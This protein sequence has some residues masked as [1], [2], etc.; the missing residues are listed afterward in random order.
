LARAL[1]I[2]TAVN[3]VAACRRRR[4][5]AIDAMSWLL[6][7]RIRHY[8][9]NSIW[10]VP[11]VAMVLAKITVR[12]VY[13]LD[14]AMDW[15]ATLNPETTRA[16]LGTLAGAMFTFIVFV[17][18]ALLLV[19]QLA[20]AQLTPRVIGPMFRDPVTKVTL[21][22]FV[23]A[24]T[25]TLAAILRVDSEV[26]YLTSYIS[27]FSCAASVAVFLFLVDHVGKI[28]RPSSVFESVAAQAH[29]VIDSVYPRRFADAPKPPS[30]SADVLSEKSA[31]VVDSR[32]GGVLMAFDLPGL[33]SIAVRHNCVI[34]LLPQVGN[35]VAP[36]APLYR[37]YAEAEVPADSLH[38]SVAL[39]RERTME[40]DPA[41]AFRVIV[42]IA[43]KGLSPAINDP[44]T[45]VLAIDQIHHLLRHVGSRCLE[46]ERVRD[47]SGRVRLIYRTPDW[48][49]FV[50][51]AVTEIRQFGGTSI[52]IAR[53]LRAMLEDLVKAVPEERA[54]RL[55]QEL[56][57]LKQSAQRFFQDP[58]DRALAD[59]S[60]SQG[61]GGAREV[62]AHTGRIGTAVPENT[63][64]P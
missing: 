34:E 9:R 35:Y 43:S 46:D 48:E 25:F 42:D 45:A 17:C 36:G 2:G 12:L 6:R 18:S 20:S 15:D 61:V 10:I 38:Q 4:T 50:N 54:V 23:F 3:D 30:Q 49:D 7:Y 27:A 14:I 51:L 24:F 29:D 16:V 28:L 13:R 11:V 63:N 26:P 64:A 53:R 59:V 56:R 47:K 19:I 31:R 44:T 8:V 58:E 39:G 22:V 21:A 62:V 1:P 37:V 41:F 5:E 55:H 57:I 52:Q 33:I 60:D 32:R 40:Q